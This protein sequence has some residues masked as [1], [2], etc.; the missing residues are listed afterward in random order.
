MVRSP[1]R[2]AAIVDM[3]ARPSE[4]PI[5]REVLTSPE[6]RPASSAAAPEVARKA[7]GVAARPAPSI[8]STPGNMIEVTYPPS[9]VIVDCHPKPAAATN[10]SSKGQAFGQAITGAFNHL[11]ALQ[12]NTD[13]LAQQ[14]ATGE[15][16]NPA[17]YMI[18]ATETQLTTQLTVAVRNKAV[19]AYNEIMKMQV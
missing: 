11:N 4:P 6:T 17:D 14:A 12:N 19:E 2:V 18:A 15:L 5:V 10:D 7:S 1:V 8:I 3:T 9:A 13:A 16:K